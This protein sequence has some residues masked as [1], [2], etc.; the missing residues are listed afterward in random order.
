MLLV[1]RLECVSCFYPS[2]LDIAVNSTAF[3]F[4]HE[5]LTI[6]TTCEIIA[7]HFET[8][9]DLTD[10]V[11]YG[12]YSNSPCIPDDGGLTTNCRTINNP[13]PGGTKT[14]ECNTAN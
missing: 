5:S 1:I 13:N 4:D 3:F 14:H 7:T 6:D 10:Y 9:K 8:F 11:I 2:N 12:G